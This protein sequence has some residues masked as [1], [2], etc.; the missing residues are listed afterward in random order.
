MFK[1]LLAL[2]ILTAVFAIG[3]LV[4]AATTASR[5]LRLGDAAAIRTSARMCKIYSAAS[6]VVVILGFG[7]MSATSPYT[8]EKVAD[9][10]DVWIWLSLL[11][12]LVAAGLAFLVVVPALD[13]AAENTEAARSMVGRVAAAGGI[14]GILFAVIV[15]L[16]VY[17]PGS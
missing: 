10:G 2:H 3:P 6:V 14:V 17:R 9:V 5:G 8:H 11:L 1:V 12:W 7:L 13:K 15:F 4:H 16:M